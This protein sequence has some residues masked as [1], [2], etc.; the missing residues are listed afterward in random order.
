[1][2]WSIWVWNWG[3][4][5]YKPWPWIRALVSTAT[6]AAW[7]LSKR[8]RTFPKREVPGANVDAR[9]LRDGKA[10]KREQISGGNKFRSAVARSDFELTRLESRLVRRT[11][12]R[13]ANIQRGISRS[14]L[15]PRLS[16]FSAFIYSTGLISADFISGLFNLSILRNRFARTRIF[17]IGDIYSVRLYSSLIPRIYR[18]RQL[19]RSLGYHGER[20]RRNYVRN[21]IASCDFCKESCC[22]E[23][24]AVFGS[25]GI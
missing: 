5:K 18:V 21:C 10:D 2:K 23:N 24:S 1:M 6:T 15:L 7:K 3:V 19:L 13:D 4:L 9:R 14:A 11:D 20:C 17:S 16:I 12:N 25:A 8:C 22:K